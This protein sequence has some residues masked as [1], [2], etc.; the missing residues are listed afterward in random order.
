MTA[1]QVRSRLP[2]LF[3]MD[4]SSYD[5]IR[6]TLTAQA[7]LSVASRYAVMATALL[8]L[9]GAGCATAPLTES[10]QLSSYAGLVP[11]D[12]VMT[13]TKVLIDRKGVLAARTVRFVPTGIDARAGG[14][15]LTPKQLQLVSNAIDRSLC[16]DLSQ[17]FTIVMPG[18]QSDLVV[19]AVITDVA[20]TDTTAA[21]AS[22]VTGI[23]GK[24]ASAATGIVLPIPRLPL[25]LGSLSVEAEARDVSGRQLAAFVWARGAD[26]FTTAARIAEEADAHT[27]AGRFAGDFAKLLI[28]GTDPIAD[29]TPLLPTAQGIGEYFGSD[30]KFAACR[31][32]GRDPGLGDTI[33]SA[34]GLPPEW[35]DAGAQRR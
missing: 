4:E 27:L 6:R 33:G 14:S 23:G 13:R 30:P 1:H 32:F 16:R 12:G 22:V 9:A 11:S 26:S 7:A 25:G 19:Q 17:R 5:M 2:P 28:T 31:Q 8:P 20:K 21:G 29:P 15:G 24:V 34:V 3:Q 10:G 18:E 35:T